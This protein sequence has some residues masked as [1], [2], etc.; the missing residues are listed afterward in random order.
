MQ[1]PRFR[2]AMVALSKPVLPDL[3]KLVKVYDEHWPDQP[4]L[5]AGAAEPSSGT[6]SLRTSDVEFNVGLLPMAIPWAELSGPAE[7][8][9]HWP[10]AAAVLEKHSAHLVVTASTS[11]PDVIDL[12]LAL[13]RV[14][15]AVALSTP[16]LGIYWRG[17][18]QVHDV[19]PFVDEAKTASRERLPLYLWLRFGLVGEEDGTTSLHTTG[20]ADVADMEIE[21]PHAH[22]DPE[23][24]VDRA[25]NIAHYLLDNGPVLKDGDTI[26]ISAAERLDIR[27][28]P[29]MFDAQRRVYS[30]TLRRHGP[31]SAPN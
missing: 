24:L 27:H 4:P 1:D 22:L 23:T 30:L 6:L 7:T 17:A 3:E 11:A 10:E 26:G 2:M 25:F 28:A 8:A 14:V 18:T 16:A 21:F 19:Q 20:L 9:W 15:A 12:M 29:S 5:T 31:A 13:T